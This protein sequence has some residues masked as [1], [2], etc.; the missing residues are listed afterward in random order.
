MVAKAAFDPC[1][2][3]SYYI[4]ALRNLLLMHSVHQLSHLDSLVL[5][6]AF[7]RALK[8]LGKEPFP[9]YFPLI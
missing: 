9:T 2:T 4:T 7:Y 5:V 8:G 3:F 6:T 1:L